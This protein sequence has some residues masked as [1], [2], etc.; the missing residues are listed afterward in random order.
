MLSASQSRLV[1][2]FAFQ[3]LS[4]CL[5]TLLRVLVTQSGMSISSRVH[6]RSVAW[7][8]ADRSV[9]AFAS[10]AFAAAASSPVLN[11]P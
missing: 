10:S 7:S 2:L 11:S 4:L 3:W 9:V 6:S 1:W 5:R 8:S